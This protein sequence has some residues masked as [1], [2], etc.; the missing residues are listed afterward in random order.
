MQ[1][2]PE[3]EILAAKRRLFDTSVRPIP[4][5]PLRRA[6]LPDEKGNGEVSLER[7]ERI[8]NR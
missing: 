1:V 6:A 4:F 8:V 5:L 7:L 3:R 2:L